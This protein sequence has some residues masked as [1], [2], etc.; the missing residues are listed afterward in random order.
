M[1]CRKFHNEIIV[2]DGHSD[3]PLDIYRKRE[4]KGKIIESYHLPLLKKGGINLV[5]ANLFCNFHPESALKTAMIQLS[6]LYKELKETKEAILVLTKKDLQ[7]VIEKKKTGFILSME[8]LEPISNEITILES[9]YRLGL[10]SVILTWNNRNYFASGTNEIGGL[11][12][13]GKEAVKKIEDLGILIDLSHLNEEG[14]WDVME[15]VKRPVIASHSNAKKVFNH[16]R[17]LTDEQMK[18]IA[19]TGGVIGLNSQFTAD[20]R[21]ENLFTFMEQLEYMISV[22]GEDHVGLGLDF[23]FYLGAK[24]TDKLNDCTYVPK[25]TEEMIKRGYSS[26]TIRKVLGEN[27][28]GIFQK[29]LP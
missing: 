8:G 2:V 20:R 16:K 11:S 22:V 6:D 21:N 1:D 23:N 24:G 9:F 28:I 7:E 12:K 17:N 10:R 26:R 5:V 29:I 13:L 27:F 19:E 3:I 18:A 15:L 14:F 25:I 4:E